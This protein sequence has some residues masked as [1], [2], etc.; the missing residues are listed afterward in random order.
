[1]GGSVN[2]GNFVGPGSLTPSFGVQSVFVLQVYL[3][4]VASK[5]ERETGNTATATSVSEGRGN[6]FS[7]LSDI[8]LLVTA[9]I[10]MGDRHWTQS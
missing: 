4:I 10:P 2:D 5:Y 1:M 9:G 7:P 6:N 3:V 8:C